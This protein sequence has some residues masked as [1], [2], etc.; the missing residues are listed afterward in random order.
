M[1]MNLESLNTNSLDWTDT[2]N[3]PETVEK[4]QNATRKLWEEEEEKER[5]GTNVRIGNKKVVFYGH[6]PDW[7]TFV[8]SKKLGMLLSHEK[9]AMLINLEIT[10]ISHILLN[11]QQWILS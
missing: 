2:W 5:N 7:V 4:R 8:T 1:R 3:S 10:I 11:Q 6:I 9:N